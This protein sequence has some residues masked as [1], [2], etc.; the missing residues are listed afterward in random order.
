M[1]SLFVLA[2]FSHHLIP[3]L[4]IPLLPYIR[5]DLS[6]TYTQAGWLVSAYS[7][8]YGISQLPS[9]W[10]A[11]RIGPR[12]VLTIGVAGVGVAGLLIG[13]APSRQFGSGTELR[14]QKARP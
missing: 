3:A 4:L 2:H 10:L 14:Y 9:G 13:L 8:A 12:I 7:L 1:L 6:L 11:D 5:D